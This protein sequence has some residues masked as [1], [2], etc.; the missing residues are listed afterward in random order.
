MLSGLDY[1]F[2]GLVGA[3]SYPVI[4]RLKGKVMNVAF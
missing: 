2:W 4:L 3:E 1:N